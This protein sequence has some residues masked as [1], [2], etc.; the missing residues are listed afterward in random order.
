M[1]RANKNIDFNLEEFDELEHERDQ[2]ILKNKKER[3][4]KI[5]LGICL[6]LSLAICIYV[7][8]VIKP[9]N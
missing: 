9:F 4:G 1:K 8:L 7:L 5:T 2:K 6:I 3:K